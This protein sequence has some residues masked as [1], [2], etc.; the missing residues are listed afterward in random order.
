MDLCSVKYMGA[1]CTGGLCKACEGS[2]GRE[3]YV[4]VALALP[5]ALQPLVG[6]AL[7]APSS[8]TGGV[9]SCNTGGVASLEKSGF[10]WCLV[11]IIVGS[12]NFMALD[13]KSIWVFKGLA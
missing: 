3:P 2:S 9:S 1:Y 13:A 5:W 10:Y 11:V 6:N 8:N 12:Q 7:L 4:E